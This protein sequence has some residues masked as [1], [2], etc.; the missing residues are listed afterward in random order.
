MHIYIIYVYISPQTYVYTIL[1]DILWGL[2]E[3]VPDLPKFE[4]QFCK[5]V[6]KADF[7]NQ[8]WHTILKINFG[9]QIWKPFV[10]MN[11]ERQL[12]IQNRLNFYN[13]I[14]RILLIPHQIEMTVATPTYNY[15]KTKLNNCKQSLK[16]HNYLFRKYHTKILF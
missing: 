6:L 14:H 12:H 9:N 16:I 1:P 5:Q 10:G 11:F 15:L 3:R 2:P 4:N 13:Y 7:E 8:F